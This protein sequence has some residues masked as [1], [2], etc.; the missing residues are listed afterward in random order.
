MV[1]LTTYKIKL[2]AKNRGIKNYQSMLGEKILSIFDKSEHITENLSKNRLER[3]LRMQNL[4]LNK[5][6]QIKRMNN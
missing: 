5:L 1:K 3:I 4:S 6:E 2:I